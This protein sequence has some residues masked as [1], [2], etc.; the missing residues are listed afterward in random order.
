MPA[1]TGH[2]H[3]F[4]SRGFPGESP[5]LR[6]A[7]YG[8]LSPRG[9]PKADTRKPER[10]GRDQAASTRKPLSKRSVSVSRIKRFLEVCVKALNNIFLVIFLS[11]S[12]QKSIQSLRRAELGF[13]C[14]KLETA[15]FSLLSSEDV[16]LRGEQGIGFGLAFMK[17]V[18]RSKSNSK[19]CQT[20]TL[21][22]TLTPMKMLFA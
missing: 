5:A 1:R 17:H 7:L 14:W 8:Q 9:E 6:P 20:A 11:L 4:C 12:S 15:C 22:A 19:G 2:C 13:Q 21:A 18:Q 10:A 3:C 16:S